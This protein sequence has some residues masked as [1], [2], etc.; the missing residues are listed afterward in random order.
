MQGR[1]SNFQL[2]YN[3]VAPG[4]YAPSGAPVQNPGDDVNRS[5]V[6]AYGQGYVTVV[7]IDGDLTAAVGQTF[8]IGARLHHLNP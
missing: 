6:T 1:V 8:V 3:Q 5:D 4:I 7:P 2:T